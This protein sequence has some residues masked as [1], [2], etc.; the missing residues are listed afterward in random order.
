MVILHV[1]DIRKM[2]PEEL[3]KKF[4]DLKRELMKM[5]LQIAQG[6]APEKPGRV[7]EIKKTIARILTIQKEKR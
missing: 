3:Q 1:A 2:K 6:T 5:R 4:T 7:N